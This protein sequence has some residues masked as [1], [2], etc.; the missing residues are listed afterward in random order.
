MMRRTLLLVLT[1][2]VLLASTGCILTGRTEWSPDGRFV[3][4]RY[5]G[6]SSSGFI[7]HEVATGKNTRMLEAQ[8]DLDHFDAFW[9]DLGG[10]VS[11]TSIAGGKAL[12]FSQVDPATG[13][14]THEDHSFPFDGET[15]MFTLGPRP[16]PQD[17]AR[18]IGPL[19]TRKGND[20]SGPASRYV[21]VDPATKKL[22]VLE[23]PN[24]VVLLE[25]VRDGGLCWE[26]EK[27]KPG[28]QGKPESGQFLSVLR[29]P[30]P[31]LERIKELRLDGEAMQK[32][33]VPSPDGGKL[34]FVDEIRGVSSVTLIDRNGK[35][36]SRVVLDVMLKDGGPVAWRDDQVHFVAR[37]DGRAVYYQVTP[38]TGAV[39]RIEI[40]KE[41]HA[42][43]SLYSS[44]AVSPD[45]RMAAFP[46]YSR[47][48]LWGEEAGKVET[49]LVLVTL[50]NPVRTIPIHATGNT[51]PTARE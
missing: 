13:T 23:F 47:P 12:R 48:P 21:R 27:K 6:E 24:G 46:V 41:V 14:V 8:Q 31:K 25:G 9:E 15:T 40:G 39:H 29:L 30:G 38:G 4:L 49:R 19:I 26:F 28:A 22:E 5:A 32:L 17:G 34:A 42:G 50:E 33:P 18:W 11:A 1:L 37:V 2:Q 45:G 7:L 51:S 10:S 20:T 3:L 43:D 36:L 16:A 44:P 35:E